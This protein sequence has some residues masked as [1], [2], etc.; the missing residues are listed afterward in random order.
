MNQL[1]QSQNKKMYKLHH[2]FTQQNGGRGGWTKETQ[3][4][5]CTQASKIP[6]YL[7]SPIASLSFLLIWPFNTLFLDLFNSLTL[8]LERSKRSS[9]SQ[10]DTPLSCLSSTHT[11]TCQVQSSGAR[12]LALLAVFAAESSPSH[13]YGHYGDP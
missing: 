4:S 8:T 5:R 2:S 10:A 11:A 13:D 7:L 9:L 12:V 3:S 6:V 1:S